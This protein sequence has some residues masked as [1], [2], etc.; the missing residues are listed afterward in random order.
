MTVDDYDVDDDDDDG[1]LAGAV[2]CSPPG[3]AQMKLLSIQCTRRKGKGTGIFLKTPPMKFLLPQSERVAYN[4][5]HRS[6]LIIIIMVLL[7]RPLS[8]HYTRH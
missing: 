7:L 4:K 2:D 8:L 6:A 3:L 5:R 1:L